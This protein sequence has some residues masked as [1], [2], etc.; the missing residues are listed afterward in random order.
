VIEGSE[1]SGGEAPPLLVIKGDATAEEVA[2]LT[3]V[4]QAMAAAGA[5]AR[6]GDRKPRSEWS[7]HHRKL[8]RPLAAG[9][10]AWRASGLPH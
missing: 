4:L 7:A 3:A 2:A 9:P 6:E 5:M 10:G 8:T 1:R